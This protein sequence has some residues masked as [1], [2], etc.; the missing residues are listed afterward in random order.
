MKERKNFYV[1]LFHTVSRWELSVRRS[2]EYCDAIVGRGRENFFDKCTFTLLL[3]VFM[4]II[5]RT[6]FVLHHNLSRQLAKE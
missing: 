4:F 2:F 1:L 5:I 3:L 6:V